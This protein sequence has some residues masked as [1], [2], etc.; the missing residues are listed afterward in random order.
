[1]PP[2]ITLRKQDWA[3]QC[4]R[5]WILNGRLAPAQRLDQEGLAQEL[6]ISRVPLR[7]ALARLAAEGLVVD[8]PHQRWVVARVSPADVRDVYHGREALETMLAF[9][10]AVAVTPAQLQ[11]IADLLREQELATRRGHAD[12]ARDLDRRF[13][14]AIY[15]H[16]RM[17]RSLE[18]LEQLCTLSDW[19]TSMYASDPGSSPQE[20]EAI[21]A[22]LREGDAAAVR[23]ATRAHIRRSLGTLTAQLTDE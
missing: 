4:L 6:E 21:L 17:P 7:Q 2:P 11:R 22:A 3:Y 5:D 23:E 9:N 14:N 18:L 13:H 10:A 8:R 20:H 16:A 1:M 19:Y 15:E 12:R